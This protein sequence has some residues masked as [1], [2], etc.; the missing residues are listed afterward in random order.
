[1]KISNIYMFVILN[2]FCLYVKNYIEEKVYPSIQGQGMSP[3][4]GF[5]SSKVNIIV[6]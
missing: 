5:G 1:M 3:N 6:K 4:S 2:Y